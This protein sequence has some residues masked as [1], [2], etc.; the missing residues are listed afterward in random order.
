MP[1]VD[2][3]ERGDAASSRECSSIAFCSQLPQS[4]ISPP[5]RAPRP[6]LPL[7]SPL[8]SPSSSPSSC[9]RLRCKLNTPLSRCRC[10]AF[11]TTP[12]NSEAR[13]VHTRK[14]LPTTVVWLLT[15]T[16]WSK[17]MVANLFATPST[18]NCAAL[19]CAPV[20]TVGGG[21]EGREGG[22]RSKQNH[23]LEIEQMPIAN[24]YRWGARV[25]VCGAII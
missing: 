9:A 15:L 18:V 17:R 5:A 14:R 21:K 16:T 22:G 12:Y 25:L 11:V 2:S 10:A 4:L 13:I 8:S 23:G 24:R 1:G 7:S 6:P 20:D 3:A 19:S